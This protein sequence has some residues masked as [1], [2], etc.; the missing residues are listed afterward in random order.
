MFCSQNDFF[1]KTRTFG[2]FKSRKN[3]EKWT[4]KMSQIRYAGTFLG[5]NS[6]V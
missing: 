5:K 2:M 3:F 4:K 1:E 6:N